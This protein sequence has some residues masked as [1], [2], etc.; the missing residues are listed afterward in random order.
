[1][2]RRLDKAIINEANLEKHYSFQPFETNLPMA[3]YWNEEKIHDGVRK[4]EVEK[5]DIKHIGF[6]AFDD[7]HDKTGCYVVECYKRTAPIEMIFLSSILKCWGEGDYIEEIEVY[8]EDESHNGKACVRFYT[9]LPYEP[10]MNV[11]EDKEYYI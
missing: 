2:L 10:Y 5:Y 6:L 11:F 1:M 8:S 4:V 9:S 3:L 7:N